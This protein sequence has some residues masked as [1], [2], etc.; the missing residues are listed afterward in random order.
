ME[1]RQGGQT[2]VSE[3][4]IAVFHLQLIAIQITLLRIAFAKEG[5]QP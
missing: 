3:L 4:S 1:R 5:K 2:A